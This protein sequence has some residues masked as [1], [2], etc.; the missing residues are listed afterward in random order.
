MLGGA[1]GAA[2]SIALLCYVLFRQG[3]SLRRLSVAPRWSDIPVSY[4][5]LLLTF[6]PSFVAFFLLSR[7][8]FAGMEL[9]PDRALGGVL[10]IRPFMALAYL[11]LAAKEELIVHAYLISEVLDLTGDAFLAVAASV[12]FQTLYHLYQGTQGALIL[13]GFFLVSSIYY[14]IY[15]RVTP[16]IV[17]HFF[18]NILVHGYFH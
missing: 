3:R 10:R 8:G 16:L 15:R 1:A 6:L 12:V 4:V 5:L 14:V 17:A 13:A 9:H 7:R 18:H 2:A 11:V